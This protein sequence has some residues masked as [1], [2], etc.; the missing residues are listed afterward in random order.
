MS[1]FEERLSQLNLA[2]FKNEGTG[3]SKE[4]KHNLFKEFVKQ[5]W[6][7][8]HYKNEAVLTKINRL[9]YSPHTIKNYMSY[10]RTYIQ[11]GKKHKGAGPLFYSLID[12]FKSRCEATLMP[13]KYD[14]HTSRGCYKP[15]KCVPEISSPEQNK[16]YKYIEVEK[17]PEKKEIY[18]SESVMESVTSC[19]I[20]TYQSFGVL[21][22]NK[23]RI[24]DTKEYCLGFID[25]YKTVGDGKEVKLIKVN[26][27]VIDENN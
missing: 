1:T 26:Y 18:V 3:T 23:I 2:P 4:I 9:H 5:L 13:S 7:Y 10:L 17:T 21:C 8:Q 11:Y 14:R 19:L 12:E 15:R 27:E 6:K 16:E 24:F 25:C 22:E 20:P